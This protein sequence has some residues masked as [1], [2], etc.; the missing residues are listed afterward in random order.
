MILDALAMPDLPSAPFT[1]ALPVRAIVSMKINWSQ[2]HISRMECIS[3]TV[4]GDR[5][6]AGTTG[7]THHTVAE[8]E[9]VER[10][11]SRRAGMQMLS[12]MQRSLGLELAR[13]HR[14][15]L[16]LVDLHLP[17]L[18]GHEVLR[19]LRAEERLRDIPVVMLSADAT[20]GQIARLQSAGAHACLAK[21]IEVKHCLESLDATLPAPREAR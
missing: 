10:I 19:R 20:P 17:D 16:I 15:D 21:P 6:I 12:A 11:L 2:R 8:M 3:P 14:P 7:A 4:V 13:Q 1:H 9:L 5:P 18:P